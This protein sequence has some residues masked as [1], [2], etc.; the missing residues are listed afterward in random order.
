MVYKQIYGLKH[1]K[2][3]P[4]FK[5]QTASLTPNQTSTLEIRPPQGQTWVVLFAR[6][7][8]IVTG[9]DTE[10]VCNPRII[11]VAKDG[12]ETYLKHIVKGAVA[13]SA[14]S[15][16]GQHSV[17]ISANADGPIQLTFDNYL[18]I[19]CFFNSGA[20]TPATVH[21]TAILQVI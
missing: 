15:G 16:G 2:L 6:A 17:E 3:Q 1:F 19:E 20:T 14:T 11:I 5:N 10:N 21:L 13:F 18:K 8:F 12:T 4:V 7:A 9:I